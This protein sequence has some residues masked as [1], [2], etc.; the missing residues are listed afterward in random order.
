MLSMHL[1]AISLLLA[2]AYTNLYS[3]LILTQNKYSKYKKLVNK[4]YKKKNTKIKIYITLASVRFREST[5]NHSSSSSSNPE[6]TNSK[7]LKIIKLNNRLQITK[8][9]KLIFT[10]VSKPISLHQIQT[11]IHKNQN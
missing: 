9:N 4:V 2:R 11:Q 1:L 3:L 5:T 8:Y 6:K 7:E 10:N